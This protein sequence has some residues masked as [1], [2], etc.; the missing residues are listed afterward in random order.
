MEAIIAILIGV[1]LVIGLI[2]YDAFSWGFV[3]SKF[4]VWFILSAFPVLPA[5]GYLQFV[6]IM[7]FLSVIMPKHVDTAKT[8]TDNKKSIMLIFSP[9][10]SLIIGWLFKIWFF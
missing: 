6:G 4:Y 9:W 3:A 1:A 5:I 10:I 2:L 8:E 7:I